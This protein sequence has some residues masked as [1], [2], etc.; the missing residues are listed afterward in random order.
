M[1]F[2]RSGV[3]GQI[4]SDYDVC[5]AQRNTVRE[6]VNEEIYAALRR[7]QLL[8]RVH[9]HKMAVHLEQMR[10]TKFESGAQEFVNRCNSELRFLDRELGYAARRIEEG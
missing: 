4:S 10:G 1:S 6:N 8:E 2:L 3:D 5:M 9:L 7:M